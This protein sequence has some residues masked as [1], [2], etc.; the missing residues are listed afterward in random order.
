MLPS[1]LYS[2]D[3]DE[4][5]RTGNVK[6][7]LWTLSNLA[8]AQTAVLQQLFFEEEDST[9]DRVMEL[10]NK[11]SG[12]I[13]EV[14]HEAMFFICNLATT[15]SLEQFQQ[16]LLSTDIILLFIRSLQSQKLSHR[17]TLLTLEAISR[18]LKY[19]EGL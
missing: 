13:N 9:L 6:R 15:C 5:L 3:K 1:D 7:A 16:K 11:A 2:S 4:I 8:A 10:A 14:F 19:D 17:L 12:Y 18:Y